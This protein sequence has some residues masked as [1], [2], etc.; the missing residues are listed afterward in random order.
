MAS[1]D[2]APVAKGEA[3][4]PVCGMSVATATARWV[5][6]YREA[7]YYFCARGCKTTFDGNPARYV[8]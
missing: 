5:S 2:S 1:H 6:D 8:S 3:R 4:D 7:K